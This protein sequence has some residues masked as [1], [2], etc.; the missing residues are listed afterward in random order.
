MKDLKDPTNLVKNLKKKNL[1]LKIPSLALKKNV[2]E[3]QT[4]I[5]KLKQSPK[6]HA[7]IKETIQSLII[8]Q[9]LLAESHAL[10]VKTER[11]R[12]KKNQTSLA[13]RIEREK[14]LRMVEMLKSIKKLMNLKF[15]TKKNHKKEF[16]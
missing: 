3:L 13:L 4:R 5:K 10:V 9:S 6:N 7:R 2:K 14:T 12:L 11:Q 1:N 15:I 16:Y 8:E